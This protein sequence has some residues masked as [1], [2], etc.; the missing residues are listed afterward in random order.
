MMLRGDVASSCRLSYHPAKQAPLT[1][2]KLKATPGFRTSAKSKENHDTNI[3]ALILH[4]LHTLSKDPPYEYEPKRKK[5]P[6]RV[7]S[8]T[9]PCVDQRNRFCPVHWPIT[10]LPGLLLYVTTVPCQTKSSLACCLPR[11]CIFLNN[12]SLSSPNGCSSFVSRVEES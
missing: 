9:T 12:L 10:P 2:S 1:K 6:G 7:A 11:L 5:I 8:V 3:Q 4:P